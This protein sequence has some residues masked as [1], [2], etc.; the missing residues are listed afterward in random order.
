M[1]SVAKGGM[2]D[3]LSTHIHFI[4][5]M[6]VYVGKG[7]NRSKTLLYLCLHMMH[8]NDATRG[9]DVSVE[10]V[11][12]FTPALTAILLVV[13]T[14]AR[15]QMQV[16]STYQVG[17]IRIDSEAC[18]TVVDL[19]HEHKRSHETHMHGGVL[20]LKTECK[21]TEHTL[22]RHHACLDRALAGSHDSACHG[23]IRS[24]TIE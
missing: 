21:S 9:F 14:I 19:E 2:R 5:C 6:Q 18:L 15:P 1:L 24:R 8:P 4:I 7:H 17:K 3:S 16:P 10:S 12:T 23:K 22:I 13:T 11:A 20:F